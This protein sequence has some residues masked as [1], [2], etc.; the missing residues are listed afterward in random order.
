MTENCPVEQLFFIPAQPPCQSG[1]LAVSGGPTLTHSSHPPLPHAW[2]ADIRV[3]FL[4]TSPYLQQARDFLP[5][6][7][8]PCHSVCGLSPPQSS[9]PSCLCLLLSASLL[10]PGYWSTT[11]S[12]ASP[13][14]QK[15]CLSKAPPSP[16]PTPS[17]SPASREQRVAVR[18]CLKPES[19]DS[20]SISETCSCV[21]LGNLVNPSVASFLHE[22]IKVFVVMLNEEHSRNAETQ[23]RC[24]RRPSEVEGFALALW[25]WQCN[26]G[27][28]AS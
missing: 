6:L 25:R 9:L 3:I 24:E 21:P 2:Y 4:I 19:A 7:L 27:P 16:A 22:E 8:Q 11:V 15:A 10:S 13:P 23:N 1:W 5:A 17:P 14:F 28:H 20:N 26:L 12:K 18:T